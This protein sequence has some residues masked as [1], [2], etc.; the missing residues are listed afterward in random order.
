[1][2]KLICLGCWDSCVRGAYACPALLRRRP[3]WQHSLWLRE[4]SPS[5]SSVIL[6]VEFVCP[7]LRR[8]R[9]RLMWQHSLWLRESG[10]RSSYKFS[11]QCSLPFLMN[12]LLA[13]L[14]LVIFCSFPQSRFV[15]PIFAVFL[16]LKL[17]AILCILRDTPLQYE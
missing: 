11:M 17:F 10:W 15:C 8:R 16:L 6:P 4:L 2:P 7:T 9:P 3:R 12:M 14:T 1:M 13:L 5:L